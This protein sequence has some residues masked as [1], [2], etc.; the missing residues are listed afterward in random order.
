MNPLSL[1]VEYLSVKAL[2]YL[3]MLISMPIS[4]GYMKC[5]F[6][7]WLKRVCFN[8]EKKKRGFG[9]EKERKRKN[10]ERRSKFGLVAFLP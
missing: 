4:Y 5:E 10:K 9:V 6:G 8:Y 2:V 1:F 7:S 3:N